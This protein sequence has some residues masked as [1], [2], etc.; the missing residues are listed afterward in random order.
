MYIHTQSNLLS[1]SRSHNVNFDNV[2]VNYGVEFN[3]NL[4]AVG[5]THTH[6]IIMVSRAVLSEKIQ[7]P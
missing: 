7:D 5:R 4:D 6:Q 1:I 2:T 3:C